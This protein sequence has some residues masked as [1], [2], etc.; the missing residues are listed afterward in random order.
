[1]PGVGVKLGNLDFGVDMTGLRHHLRLPWFALA[2]IV[3]ML[4]MVGEASAR[5][6]SGAAGARKSCCVVSTPADCCCCPAK[7][8]PLAPSVGPKAAIVAVEVR[9]SASDRPCE[10]RSD[11]PAAPASRLESSPTRLLS[12][13]AHEEVVATAFSVRPLA[14]LC[15]FDSPPGSPPKSPI[16]L[17]TTRLLI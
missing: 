12:E 14:S 11:E 6:T 8:E 3:G 15:R 10:C 4:S 13:R 17:L 16:Y 2:A 7:A 1:M 9:L 5:S